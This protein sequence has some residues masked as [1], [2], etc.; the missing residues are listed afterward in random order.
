MKAVTA[1]AAWRER[2][3]FVEGLLGLKQPPAQPAGVACQSEAQSRK[4]YVDAL[5][6][7]LAAAEGS[8]YWHSEELAGTRHFGIWSL[9]EA[10]QACFGRPE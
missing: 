1:R 5:G 10:A 6:F 3:A 7:P 9:R 4:L 8:G 2:S